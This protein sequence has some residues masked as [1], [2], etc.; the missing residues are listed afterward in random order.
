[1]GKMGFIDDGED[2]KVGEVGVEILDLND[3]IRHAINTL[4]EYMMDDE[5][6][7]KGISVSVNVNGEYTSNI[8]Y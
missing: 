1:M 6:V 4:G 8:K 2:A 7:I 3:T 5:S